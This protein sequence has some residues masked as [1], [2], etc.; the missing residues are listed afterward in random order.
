M[1]I[2]KD[3]EAIKRRNENREALSVLIK[4]AMEVDNLTLKEIAEKLHMEE[5][6]VRSLLEK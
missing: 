3:E 5:S 2:I 6:S 1:M 4:K